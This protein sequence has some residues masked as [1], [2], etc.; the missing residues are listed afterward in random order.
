MKEQHF[1]EELRNIVRNT[2]VFAGDTL[3]H[4]TVKVCCNRD[5]AYQKDG[6]YKPTLKGLFTYLNSR[7]E[8]K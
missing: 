4:E 1:Y 2:P 5:W 7:L 8:K 3:S 6:D